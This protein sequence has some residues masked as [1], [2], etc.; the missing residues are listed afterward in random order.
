VESPLGYNPTFVILSSLKALFFNSLENKPPFS[1]N[2]G[3]EEP[4][5]Q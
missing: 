5:I 3:A 2:V 1:D 4:G